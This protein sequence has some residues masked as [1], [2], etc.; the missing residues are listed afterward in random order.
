MIDIMNNLG[1]DEYTIISIDKI[2][3][4]TKQSYNSNV[5]RNILTTEPKS[6]IC[7][8]FPYL[9]DEH[10]LDS[11][12]SVYA[13]GRDYHIWAKEKLTQ[14]VIEFK[15][16]YKE[17]NFA[18]QV[19]NGPIDERF[20]ALKS[21]LG[22]RGLNSLII[23]PKYG[24]YGFVGIIVTDLM[25]AEK[26]IQMGDCSLCKACISACPGS[27]IKGDF[28]IDISKCASYLSQKK[29]EL[30]K[31]E[32]VILKKS[33]KIFGCDICQNICLHNIKAK[34]TVSDE[35]LIIELKLSDI[36]NLSNRE[37][38]DKY[39]DRAFAWRGKNVLIRNL[40][41]V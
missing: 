30:S 13:Q 6:V 40:Y 35:T 22:L 33:K 16:Q 36:E 29:S 32:E 27:A 18:I 39:G 37:F 8:F 9:S 28:T 2:K 24:S 19:D 5:I 23:N 25:F 3:D 20:F 1:I 21:G 26:S 10:S 31:E 15:K 17:C 14:A 38:K 34:K 41:I 12:I 4:E 7:I 11:N